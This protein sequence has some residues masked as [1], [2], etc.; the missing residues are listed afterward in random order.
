MG[1]GACVVEGFDISHCEF[2]QIERGSSILDT[3]FVALVHVL[4]D[5]EHGILE[6]LLLCGG[7][8]ALR[9]SS[10]HESRDCFLNFLAESQLA[11]LPNDAG[12]IALAF[13][14][15][16]PSLRF[17]ILVGLL[18]LEADGRGE[19]DEVEGGSEAFHFLVCLSEVSFLL[20]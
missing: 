18:F 19:D 2:A 15:D 1:G 17:A 8:F 3:S 5:I 16:G 6:A 20:Y 13:V 7:C 4:V 9:F 10:S 12:W 11:K 14:P